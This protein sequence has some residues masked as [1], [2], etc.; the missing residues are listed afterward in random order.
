MSQTFFKKELVLNQFIVR[1]N[2]VQFE[3]ISKDTGILVLDEGSDLAGELKDAA[4]KRR[5]GI[6][7]ITKDEYD[8]LKKNADF[9]PSAPRSKQVLRVFQP[10]A[11][12]DATVRPASEK[13]SSTPAAPPAPKP[14]VRQTGD[15]LRIVTKLQEAPR[16]PAAPF[17]PATAKKGGRPKKTASV[18]QTTETAAT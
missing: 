1:G 17:K 6:V 18:E 11:K 16:E 14:E 13:Q 2:P 4:S 15:L 5:G 12:S 10:A 7:V 8:E 3:Q 9:S